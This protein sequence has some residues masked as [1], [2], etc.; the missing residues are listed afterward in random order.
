METS[1]RSSLGIPIMSTSK[2]PGTPRRRTRRQL[3]RSV[4]LGR[5][6]LLL[7][8]SLLL[9]APLSAQLQFTPLQ[10]ESYQPQTELLSVVRGLEIHGSFAF[11]LQENQGQGTDELA[12]P[13]A[14]WLRLRL[15]SVVHADAFLHLELDLDPYTH[16]D[17]L[18][19]DARLTPAASSTATPLPASNPT[20]TSASPP[21]QLQVRQAYLRYLFNPRSAMLIGRQELSVGDRRGKTFHGIGRAL[22]LDCRVNTWCL[23]LG[24]I[25]IG[26]GNADWLYHVALTYVAWDYPNP[27]ANAR[28]GGWRHRFSTEIYRLIYREDNVPLGKDLGP[29]RVFSKGE[30][31][32]ANSPQLFDL[33]GTPLY[34]DAKDFNYY[35][36]R[37][38]LSEGPFFLDLDGVTAQGDRHYH[39]LDPEDDGFRRIESVNGRALEINLG[40]RWPKHRLGLRILRASGD[41]QLDNAQPAQ[42]SI[43][44]SVSGYHEITPGSYQGS[45]FYFN[46]SESWLNWGP[47]PET[48]AYRDRS[49]TRPSSSTAARSAS[50]Y[51]DQPFQG[52]TLMQASGGGLGHSIHN[53]QLSGLFYDYQDAQESGIGYAFGLYYLTLAEPIRDSNKQLQH[54]IGWEINNR[55]AWYFHRHVH[56]ELELNGIFPGGAFRSTPDAIPQA[57]QDSVSQGIFRLLYRF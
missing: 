20:T 44:R 9:A 4:I 18:R 45:R 46:G 25:R 31:T 35:G 2:P 32:L 22:T 56:L 43:F 37:F 19:E 11:R 10:E 33:D 39:R 34:Y 15:R 17:S 24:A 23:P 54:V 38:H 21:P 57:P 52:H 47:Q 27:N 29:A 1:S 14:E 55:F 26:P 8:G 7:G 28:R 36:L 12:T 53:T 30:A 6:S 13:P 41:A 16:S 3:A 51:A 49:P 48:F 50:S 42:D 40:W 5:L